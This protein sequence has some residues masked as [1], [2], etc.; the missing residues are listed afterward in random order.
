MADRHVVAIIVKGKDKASGVLRGIGG[1]LGN[2][3]KAAAVGLGALGAG[4]AAAGIGIAKLASDAAPLEG[5]EK[6]FDGLAESVGKSGDEL[7]QSLEEGSLG[8]INQRDLMTSFND[9]AQ[10][11]S[12]DFAQLLPDAM[13]SL[14]KVAASTGDDVGFMLE[15]LTTGVGRLSPQILDN[16]KIQ[17]D[18][19]K[20]YDDYAASIGKSA[21]EL[22]KQE[23]QMALATQAIE[24]LKENTASMPDITDNA[25]TKQ[26]QLTAK[27][28]NTKDTIG[29]ALL[30][31]WG[32]ML[33][34]VAEAANK[35]L[36]VL[37][38]VFQK[39]V[40]P[41][42]TNKV[43]PAIDLLAQ[44]LGENIPVAIDKIKQFYDNPLKPTLDAIWAFIQDPLIPIISEVVD[45]LEVNLPTAFQAVEDVWNSVLKPV[46]ELLWG[47][48]QDPLIPIVGDLVSWLSD[49][50]P[51]AFGEIKA[52]WDNTLKPTFEAIFD[53]I[54]HDLTPALSGMADTV[55]GAF[56]T[57]G[58]AIK[59]TF[60]TIIGHIE[61][62][63]NTA[64]EGI[65]WLVQQA[66]KVPGVSIGQVAP[67][68]LPRLNTGGLLRQ[69]TLAQVHANEVVLPLDSQ[70]TVDALARAMGKAGGRGGNQFYYNT[71]VIE[72][73]QDK[74]SLFL[75]LQAIGA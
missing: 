44:W 43:V 71:F 63:I 10:L 54:E 29:K 62:A 37:I 6:S 68:S 5:I 50:I 42:I 64:I 75:E 14:S 23:Q 46:L 53:F 47:F 41:F 65:N 51:D 40:V 12:T 25:S 49:K 1:A 18:A 45:W 11:V 27:L 32:T 16:L 72:G 20:A 48:I 73:V 3:G 28:E 61:S 74:D 30:P 9:A 17:V 52:F 39:D 59:G 13:E 15:S 70:Q 7:I 8:M 4:T 35:Y 66:N 38:D 26:A 21:D 2:L 36:P 55:G 22:T 67:V 33:D 31:I 69:D 58:G 34:V 57:V 24:L 19:T 60:N 56:E